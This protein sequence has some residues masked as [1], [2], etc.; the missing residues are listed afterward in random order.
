M[1]KLKELSL[2]FPAY[3][4]EANL[5]ETVDKAIPHLQEVAQKYEILIVDDGSKDKTGEIAD[6][7]AK[8]YPFIRVVH[9]NPNRGYGG[10][11]QSGWYGCRYEW[12]TFTDADGQFD[13]SEISRFID[14]QER[15]GADLVIGYYLKRAVGPMTVF[16]SKI[17]ELMVFLLFGLKV[18][19]IDCGFKL[20]RKK[21][22]DTIPRLESER[23]PFI[24]SELLIK[25]KKAGFKFAE[26]G[27]HHYPRKA[28]QATGRSFKVILSGFQDLFKLRCKI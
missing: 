25:A 16:T 18:T 1:K 10:A 4:E 11:M 17:W 12:I 28:G 7:L 20:V 8:K 23:G 3:N 27:V 19:D 2:F 9:H 22:I 14:E 24:T 21:V 6:K 26:V 5:K 13:F 15:T